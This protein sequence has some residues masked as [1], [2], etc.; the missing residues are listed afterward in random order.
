[1]NESHRGCSEHFMT[2]A[3]F[4]GTFCVSITQ[5]IRTLSAIGQYKCQNQIK[6]KS[7]SI[8][9]M[10]IK[11]INGSLSVKLQI[12]VL[13]TILNYKFGTHLYASLKK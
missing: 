2:Q 10:G 9:A 13:S 7:E 11:Q 3:I 12:S 8:L 4:P 6:N 5:P 1:M